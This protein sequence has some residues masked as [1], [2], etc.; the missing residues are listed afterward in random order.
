MSTLDHSESTVHIDNE[1]PDLTLNAD[2]AE[3]R[4]TS[5]SGDSIHPAMVNSILD[6]VAK[7]NDIVDGATLYEDCDVVGR[8]L[9]PPE[10]AVGLAVVELCK[11]SHNPSATITGALAS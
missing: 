2:E 8:Y 6:H 11:A 10:S 4:L 7:K 9:N 3:P 1:G 5:A